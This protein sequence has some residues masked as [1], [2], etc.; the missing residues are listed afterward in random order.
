MGN[1]QERSK[2]DLEGIVSG[3][4]RIYH[5]DLL[6]LFRNAIAIRERWC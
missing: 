4:E 1:I 3:G 5:C 2:E 6:M